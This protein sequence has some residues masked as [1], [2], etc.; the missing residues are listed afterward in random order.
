MTNE[1][2]KKPAI[3]QHKP[4]CEK[5]GSTDVVFTYTEDIQGGTIDEKSVLASACYYLGEYVGQAATSE[6][7]LD[8]YTLSVISRT[9]SDLATMARV[10]EDAAEQAEKSPTGTQEAQS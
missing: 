2:S 9:L 3:D 7:G 10:R 8:A 4:H 6:D 1:P 5:C